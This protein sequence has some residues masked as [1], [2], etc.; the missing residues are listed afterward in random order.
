VWRK[1]SV[2]SLF[3]LFEMLI[4]VSAENESLCSGTPSLHAVVLEACPLGGCGF[5]IGSEVGI[6][7]WDE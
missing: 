4:S 5:G 3:L 7:R 6:N 2:S 1:T